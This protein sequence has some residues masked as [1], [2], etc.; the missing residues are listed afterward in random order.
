MRLSDYSDLNCNIDFLKELTLLDKEC[1][2][3][4]IN[5]IGSK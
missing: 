5:I 4:P 3:N 2:L 1:V